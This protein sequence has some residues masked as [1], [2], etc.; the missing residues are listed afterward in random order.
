MKTKIF[1]D[2]ADI[3]TAKNSAEK[4]NKS[5]TTNLA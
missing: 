1:C 4:N 3:T 5:F 2:I